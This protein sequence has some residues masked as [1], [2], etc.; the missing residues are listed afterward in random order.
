M[1]EADPPPMPAMPAPRLAVVHHRAPEWVSAIRA[2]APGLDVRGWRPRDAA[3]AAGADADWLAGAEALFAWRFPDGFLAKMPGLRWIQNA[4]AGVDHLLGHPEVPRGVSV[5]RAD[6]R[7]G[8][9]I[10]RYV[11]GHLL[12][13]AQR[14]EACRAAQCARRWEGGLLPERLHGRVALVAGFGRIGRR[15]GLAL[16]ALGMEVRGF[17][18]RGRRDTDFKVHSAERLA[19]HVPEARALVLCAPA[20]E[21]T[22]GLVNAGLLAGGRPDL[23]LI[24]VARGCLVVLPDV[25]A[26]LDAG[27]LGRAVLDV[28]PDEP[29]APGDALWGH[30]RVTVTPHHAGPTL[31][32]DMLRDMLP[33]LL[34]Y[35]QGRPIEG[36]VDR[37]RGY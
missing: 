24:N 16:K 37:E 36:A 29:L 3:G 28:F 25:L 12:Y 11:C 2:A 13:E 10:A 17:A 26:A 20:L 9:W 19:E 30:P 21:S 5:T 6:G 18:A 8:L 14:L 22:R 4:G 27:R 23:T 1:S 32:E 34:A 7:F 35:A 33:N 15:V 31:P